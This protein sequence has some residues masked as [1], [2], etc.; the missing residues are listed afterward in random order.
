MNQH[1]RT[2]AYSTVGAAFL[3]VIATLAWTINSYNW[4]V[5]LMLV[6][7]FVVY[8][9]IRLARRLDAWADNQ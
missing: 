2:I 5:A 6:A 3:L 8:G 9:L 7:P 1:R 4:G